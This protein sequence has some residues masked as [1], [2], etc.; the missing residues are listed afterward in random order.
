VPKK[1]LKS[2]SK[3]KYEKKKFLLKE[4]GYFTAKYRMW[5]GVKKFGYKEDF[6]K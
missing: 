4:A 1:R 5:L 3:K 6:E 2:L